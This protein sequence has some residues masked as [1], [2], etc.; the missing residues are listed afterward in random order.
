[1]IEARVVIFGSIFFVSDA[2]GIVGSIDDECCSGSVAFRCTLE[3]D[4]H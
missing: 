1:M 3:S 2:T 4:K